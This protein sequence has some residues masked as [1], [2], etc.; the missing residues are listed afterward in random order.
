MVAIAVFGW[1][2]LAA[3][4]DGAHAPPLNERD[5]Q[6]IRFRRARSHFIANA[7]EQLPN[8]PTVITW[9]LSNRIWLPLLLLGLEVAAVAGGFVLKRVEKELD[10]P[11][12]RKK[13]AK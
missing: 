10:Q 4:Y 8:L 13:P 3:S 6:E 11:T 1:G 5:P 9:H 7:V 12:R 2:F